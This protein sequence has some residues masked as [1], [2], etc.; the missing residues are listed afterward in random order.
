M[1]KKTSPRLIG[2][3]VLGA[4]A[5]IVI[6]ILAFGSGQY[7]TPTR[8]AVLFFQGNLSGLDVGAPVT[9]RGIRVGSVT[10]IVIHY[11]V[12]DQKLTIPVFIELN[13][14]RFQIVRGRQAETNI[15]E[16][17]Q[18]GLRAQLQVQSL[19]T[20]QTSVNFDFFPDTPIH[21][22]GTVP[23]VPELPTVPS[24]IDVLKADIASLLE[25][26]NKLPLEQISDQMLQAGTHINEV[27]KE[28]LTVVTG[29]SGLIKDL[30]GEVKPL[31]QNANGL[32]VEARQ[33]L[34]LRPGEPMQNLNETL[35]GMQQLVDSLNRDLPRVVGPAA[36][37][38]TRL[39]ATMDQALLL[40]QAAQRLI[41]PGS[42]VYFELT[43]TLSEF[44][45]AARALRVFAEYIQR[46]PNALLMGNK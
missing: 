29:A 8:Q 3:F 44:K 10:R 39:S 31:T 14:E 17:V 2:G 38:M 27:L 45:S 46:N 34:E 30:G 23:S 13:P 37:A 40:V 11:D 20:G 35:T 9:F 4:I 32:L 41:S 22:V 6:G 7:F 42:P 12:V 18:R 15:D 24:S 33:R 5:L 43:S 28:S 1:A 25:K 21:L 26:I 36:L 19:V 16:L